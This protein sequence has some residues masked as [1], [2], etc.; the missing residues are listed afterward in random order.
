MKFNY[1]ASWDELTKVLQAHSSVSEAWINFLNS[2]EKQ[3]KKKYWQSLRALDITT[4]QE[5][6]KDWIE[7]MFTNFPIPAD[8]KALWIGII[9]VEGEENQE[10]PAIYLIG[11][12]EYDTDDIDWA[13]NATY[14][15]D[16]RYVC[17]GILTEIDDI[18]RVDK[19]DYQ[20]LD[21]IL[22]VAYCAL[23]LDEL[24]GKKI[25]KKIALQHHS[26]LHIAVG[27]DSGDYLEISPLVA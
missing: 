26:I 27:H 1:E 16:N 7:G 14:L 3:A 24:F 9:K 4:E 22:P 20:F 10:M 23:T 21:W 2:L 12:N 25:D 18:I 8:T 11:S 5:E 6:L 19:K 17:P 15:P 13:A